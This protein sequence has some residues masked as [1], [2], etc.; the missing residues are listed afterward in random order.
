MMGL[1]L[2]QTPMH[3]IPM[4]RIRMHPT[5]VPP[6][7]TFFRAFFWIIFWIVGSL[8]WL[9][10]VDA[11]TLRFLGQQ[12]VP[13]AYEFE[14]TTVGGLSG[15]DFDPLSQRFVVISDDPSKRQPA[16]FYTLR[17]DP[18]RFSHEADPGFEAIRFLAVTTLT[19]FSGRP[20]A[21]GEVDPEAIR[22]SL[23][24]GRIVW[25]SEG[26]ARRAVPPAITE[27]GL[28]G[29]ALRA[30][31]IPGH[32]LP[33][34]GRGVRHNLAF[35]SLAIHRDTARLYIGTENALHQDGPVAD[36]GQG[37]PVR[38]L[39][40]EAAT[41]RRLSE[42]VL[43]VDAVPLDA[44]LPALLRPLHSFRTNGLVELLATADGQVLALERSFVPGAGNGARLYRIDFGEAS[45]VA[46]FDTLKAVTYRPAKKT[47][48]LDFSALGVRIDNLEGMSWGPPS[49]DG[50]PTLIFVSD[51][52]F[53]AG[54][55]TQFLAF[56]IIP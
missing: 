21:E 28:D 1:G 54:Q 32:F 24:P 45:D 22:F 6:P 44:A 38:I 51:D 39:L 9:S 4:H 40:H 37:S 14:G 23:E 31:P 50:H 29:R 18:S 42:H 33:K 12:I 3:Q 56:E 16:R 25:T 11:Q 26:N 8:L 47:L 43:E 20:Y 10:P 35:E 2:H 19:D 30:L 17:I 46:G 48:L 34:E 55:V 7:S 13:H 15:L 49:P 36:T 41:T 52:N 53:G 27:S 5:P